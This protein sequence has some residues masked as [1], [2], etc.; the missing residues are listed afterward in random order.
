MSVIRHVGRLLPKT[1]RL[2]PK[3]RKA[4]SEISEG[5]FWNVRR[6]KAST[7]IYLHTYVRTQSSRNLPTMPRR[8]YVHSLAAFNTI[9][10]AMAV[11]S[12][13]ARERIV[14]MKRMGM[15]NTEVLVTLKREGVDV[16]AQTVR[17]FCKRY[18]ASGSIARST[19]SGRPTLLST[20]VLQ[21]I[22]EMMQQ[23][24][25]TT[26]VQIR[27]Y[28]MQ[29]GIK[30]SLTTILRGR[31]SLGWTYRG[32]A[33]CQ[34]I[35]DA[36][37]RKRLEWAQ[38]HL[39]DSFEDV[40]WT[41]ETSVQ[42]E[43]HKRFCCRK[44]GER[45]RPKPRPKH[46]VKVHVW[47]G[48]GWHGPTNICIFDGIMNAAMYTRILQH[49]LLPTLR[50]EEYREGHR[51]MQDNDPK[52]T[53]RAAQ[54]FFAENGINWWRTPAESPDANPIENLWHE[55]KVGLCLTLR[56]VLCNAYLCSINILGENMYVYVYV[57]R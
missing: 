10:V 24:D 47:A 15:S 31:R 8:T 50:R 6:Q 51:F 30:L 7:D 49:A 46:P 48:I 37:K 35:R 22:E 21:L 57:Y 19:G 43:C 25:E 26:S 5:F 38:A 29:R 45:P 42:L 32:S 1:G 23:D 34:L 56:T 36:N 17:R 40:I 28:L 13:Y 55:L 16:R 9:N 53:S 12:K 4:S 54:Q 18:S 41:D 20:N 3:C 33:Y 52:H 44:T 14:R 39:Q 2:L 11:L 27:S